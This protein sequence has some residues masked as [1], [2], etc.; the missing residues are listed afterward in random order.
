MCPDL[1]VH[2]G[3]QEAVRLAVCLPDLPARAAALLVAM[4][5]QPVQ[6]RHQGYRLQVGPAAEPAR[7]CGCH[8]PCQVARAP[9]LLQGVDQ[10]TLQ[11]G[12]GHLALT[13]RPCMTAHQGHRLQVAATWTGQ[14]GACLSFWQSSWWPS[15]CPTEWEERKLATMRSRSGH[16]ASWGQLFVWAVCSMPAESAVQVGLNRQSSLVPLQR[17]TG[18]AP[19]VLSWQQQQLRR[20]SPAPVSPNA[21]C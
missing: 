9:Q 16:F 4:A 7:F 12:S 10:A 19:A 18:L 5:P 17:Q 6:G 3:A 13:Q 15:S 8:L 1:Q 21:L 14:P 2:C 11:L 20:S